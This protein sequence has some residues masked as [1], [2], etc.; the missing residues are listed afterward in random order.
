MTLNRDA[1]KNK[2]NPVQNEGEDDARVQIKPEE[3]IQQKVIIVYLIICKFKLNFYS[4][5]IHKW[6]KNRNK[7]FVFVIKTTEKQC[8]VAIVVIFGTIWIA[9]DTQKK[10]L[11]WFWTKMRTSCGSIMMLVR[12]NISRIILMP[13]INQKEIKEKNWY[14]FFLFCNFSKPHH[15]ILYS[16]YFFSSIN[17]AFI[18]E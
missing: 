15:Y 14:N 10:K 1:N 13:W 8:Y 7:H 6:S 17:N 4:K 5:I 9:W 16:L 2:Q 11:I 12:L 18:N 3:L